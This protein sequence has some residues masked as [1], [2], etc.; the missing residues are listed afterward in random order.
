MAGELG[1]LSRELWFDVSGTS[2]AGLY[3]NPV[4]FGAPDTK[5]LVDSNAVPSN[6]GDNYIQRLRGYLKP[7]TT[8][9]YT[10]WISSD[11]YSEL[12]LSTTDSKFDRVKIASL[13]GATSVNAWDDQTSQM[14][15]SIT[16]QAGQSYFLEVLHKEGSVSDHVEVAWQQAGGIRQLIPSSYIESFTLDANDLNENELPDDWE[17][18]YGLNSATA[19]DQ[20]ALADPD[21]DGFTNYEEASLGMD[22]TTH[23]RIPGVLTMD[24]WD[25][26]RGTK[27]EFLTWNP[28]FSSTPDSTEYV[29]SAATPTNRGDYFGTRLRGL[30]TAPVTGNYTFYISGDD[31]CELWLSGSESQFGKQKIAGMYGS[32]NVAQWDKYTEQQS[33]TFSLVAGQSY[34]IEAILKEA[35]VSDHMEI[36]WMTPDAT[37]ISIIPGSA[38][39]SHAFDLDDPD[40]DEMPSAWETTNGLDPMSAGD[41]DGGAADPDADG[42]QNWMEYEINSDPFTKNSI[43][44]GMAREVW[45][46]VTNS[47]S[48]FRNSTRYWDT[49]D[50]LS[51]FYGALSPINDGDNFAARGRAWLTAPTTGDYTF[52]IASDDDSELWLSPTASKFGRTKIAYVS[53]ATGQ[54][55][56]DSNASQ[57]SATIHL[58]EGE[59][60]F[61]EVLHK[62][63]GGDDHF[64]IAWQILGGSREVI[65]A[66]ALM[67]FTFDP[68]DIDNDEL[69]DSWELT[70]G[71]ST[72]DNG[73]I[74]PDQHPLAD[75]DGDGVTNLE[76]SI[77]NTDPFERF[78]EAGGLTLDTW[79]NVNGLSINHLRYSSKF[80][81]APDETEFVTSAATPANRGDNY[82]SRLR[83][84]VIAPVTGVYTFYLASDDHGE[85]WLSS[86]ESQFAKQ[87]IAYV[88]GATG[89]EQWDLF[90]SQQ[91]T[92]ISLQ[93][94]QKYYIEA[95]LKESVG[96][97]H[98]EIGWTVPGTSSIDIIPS[99]ALEGHTHD[100]EDPDGDDMPSSWEI[101]AGLDPMSAEGD[102][103]LGGDPD[104]DGIVNWL[105]YENGSSP[106]TPNRLAGAMFREVWTSNAEG[107]NINDFRNSE[108]F[109]EEADLTGVVPGGESA[110]NWGDNYTQRLR[111]IIT[112]PVTGDYSFWIS[113]DDNGELWISSSES[114]FDRKRIAYCVGT[115]VAQSWDG[116]PFQKSP[117]IHLIA[118]EKYFIE[119]LHKEGSGVDHLEIAWQIPGEAREMIPPSAIESYAGEANDQNYD[120]MRDDWEITHGFSLANTNE[121]NFHQLADPD[122]DSVPNW[123]E[124]MK[125]TDPF[126][127]GSV[128]GFLSFSRWDEMPFYSVTSTVSDKGYYDTPSSTDIMVD[129]TTGVLTGDYIASRARGY[130]EVPQS[131]NYTFWV[132]GN[133]SV[134]L[135]LS[136]DETKYKKQRI[137]RIAPE[138]GSGQGIAWSS[139]GAPWDL[140]ASQMSDPVALEA[141]H[142]YFIEV[143][144]QRGHGTTCSFSLGWACDD[145][146]RSLIPSEA[147]SS[148]TPETDDLD[149]DYLPD[150]WETSYGLNTN[151]NG[152]VDIDRE[153]E[154]GDYDHD[155]LSN[156]IEYLIGTNPTLVDSN[157]DGITDGESFYQ[158]DG[159]PLASVGASEQVVSVIDIHTPVGGNMTWSEFGDGVVGDNFRGSIAF[160]FIVPESGKQWI[161]AVEGTILSQLHAT[162]ELQIETTVDSVSLGSQLMSY[163][164]DETATMR[165]LTGVLSGGTHRVEFFIDNTIASE[166]FQLLGFEL[167][168]PTGPDLD[169]DGTIDWLAWF[170]QHN[171]IQTASG[172]SH[173]SPASVEG[174]TRYPGNLILTWNGADAAVQTGLNDKHWFADVPLNTNG[175]TTVVGSFEGGA[176]T[177]QISLNW[178]PLNLNSVSSYSIRVGDTL[179]FNYPQSAGD[180][181]Q[182]AYQVG[183]L[184]YSQHPASEGVFQTF[185][186]AGTYTLT[187]TH[188]SGASSSVEIEVYDSDFGGDPMYLGNE[189]A[190]TYT[191]LDVPAALTLQVAA[192]L[193]LLEGGAEG[194]GSY[195]KLES[196]AS[197]S[198]G[199]LARLYEGGPIVARGG[200]EV[201]GFAG[202]TDAVFQTT[203]KA[204]DVPG[205]ILV[206]SPVIITG[207][208]LGY[209][210]RVVIDRA[211]VMFLDGSTELLL[212]AEDFVNGVYMA[213]FLMPASMDGGYCHYF[214]ILDENGE[215]VAR[216]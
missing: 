182:V 18:Q 186:Q 20:L 111:G 127:A 40:G 180:T 172:E 43:S 46:N 155:G 12:W 154:R 120:E 76:E 191:Y 161:L 183:S 210:V 204:T 29:T 87:K 156:R 16:L 42:I 134:E 112:A 6:I 138:M 5:D 23:S 145:G 80:T 99:S 148:Y 216:Y 94:G 98:L 66:S 110:Q 196:T 63:G 82:G 25:G 15:V 104:R 73:T 7:A 72:S 121:G 177:H 9:N 116:H 124:S 33:V 59:S 133:T 77:N 213:S 114:K 190:N 74:Y 79:G 160:D 21:H 119:A 39:S 78:R 150:A 202:A 95:W 170:Y 36:G 129:G 4:L 132:S 167:R 175:S 60:Y 169:L 206:Q 22:P 48:D 163:P 68:D 162:K 131:G 70:H 184:S 53:G 187:A 203:Q 31:Q 24:T 81:A 215:V 51:V 178:T 88:E 103:G 159:D 139:D 100:I 192:P 198:Y 13:A 56:W 153:G 38:L 107:G 189:V 2:T 47:L 128:D 135:W 19:A 197:G 176:N 67:S 152:F 151:D 58:V 86:S 205:Y 92:G 157:G 55:S 115:T 130:I 108:R 195:A 84:V 168:R 144:H 28:R 65:P 10:F 208:P 146:E 200:I 69:L 27:V 90:S 11:D 214:E 165:V 101:A 141:G 174:S 201:M 193:R 118:G 93:A 17:L 166:T 207:L 26:I 173:T 137:A 3:E 136:T 34:Y 188:T 126:A 75:P 97:D 61:M 35:L 211:G 57:Q 37:A 109:F 158:L 122:G 85:L 8:G 199:I 14:S 45:R 83:G 164:K 113:S 181:A 49:A 71:F 64:S 44:G 142:K 62:E 179:Q 185:Q 91:S 105:E 54:Q 1:K 123:A 171:S 147:L 89:V 102:N 30:V 140:F 50:E 52:W 41:D 143:I 149:D 117:V 125:N 209:T 106:Y 212:T 194:T 96:N 32:T